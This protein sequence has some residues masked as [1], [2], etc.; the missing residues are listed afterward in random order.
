LIDAATEDLSRMNLERDYTWD[1]ACTESKNDPRANRHCRFVFEHAQHV[2]KQ[3][4]PPEVH[5]QQ[6]RRNKRPDRCDPHGCH[7]DIASPEN[8]R[9]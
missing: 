1:Y 3:S 5:R 8:E 2:E 9:G 7:S 6:N 4:R